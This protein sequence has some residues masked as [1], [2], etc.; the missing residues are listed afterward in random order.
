M[1]DKEIIAS[2]LEH[3]SPNVVYDWLEK[4]A[5]Q[6]RVFRVFFDEELETETETE[7]MLLKRNEPVIDLALA[8]YSFNEK[9]RTTLYEKGNSTLQKAVLTNKNCSH[10][11]DLENLLKTENTEYLKILLSNTEDRLF[12]VDLFKKQNVFEQI[13]K[14]YWLTLLRF[15]GGNEI[16]RY[17]YSEDDDEWDDDDD[18]RVLAYATRLYRAVYGLF[19]IL[20][21][22]KEN[23]SLLRKLVEILPKASGYFTVKEPFELIQKWQN[24]QIVKHSDYVYF[25]KHREWNDGDNRYEKIEKKCWIEENYITC[26]THLANCVRW[27]YDGF[28]KFEDSEDVALRMA[29]YRNENFHWNQEQTTKLLENWRKYYER[30]NI[31]FIENI[32]KNIYIYYNKEIRE[33]IDEGLPLLKT[34][35]ADEYQESLK[36]LQEAEPEYFIDNSISELLENTQTELVLLKDKIYSINQETVEIKQIISKQKIISYFLAFLLAIYILVS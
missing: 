19:S 23:V 3:S 29:Y 13:K 16:L 9:T 28:E 11:S 31:L 5:R 20:P 6:L 14:N 25:Q 27:G 8:L 7:L 32:I 26:R 36:K 2:F 15:A 10:F 18:I 4:N 35:Y 12:L 34:Y 1:M 30:D 33:Y 22:T 17:P 24:K 21:A